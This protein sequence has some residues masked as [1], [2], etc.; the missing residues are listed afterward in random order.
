MKGFR[1]LLPT[2]VRNT[3][4]GSGDT[5][6]TTTTVVVRVFTY[7]TSTFCEDNMSCS[8]GLLDGVC[9]F[10]STACFITLSNLIT[11]FSCSRCTLIIFEVCYQIKMIIAY[12]YHAKFMQ[13]FGWYGDNMKPVE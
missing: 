12:H 5:R 2:D 9:Q 3:D 7:T 13:K 6:H 4:P 1:G 10:C 11:I 8:N